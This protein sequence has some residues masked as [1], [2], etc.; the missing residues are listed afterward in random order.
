MR[1]GETIELTDPV[2]NTAKTYFINTAS[3]QRAR[4]Q[5]WEL[6]WEQPLWGGFGVTANASLADTTVE[7][8][9]PMPGASR[10][11]GNLGFYYENDLFSVRLLTNYRGDY[12]MTTT[13]PAP[14]ANSQGLSTIRCPPPRPS[15]LP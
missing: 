8:G 3:Q 11:A 9:R 2:D 15:R 10:K 7:D 1:Q 13:A 12:V 6:G 5:G 4:I 14:T